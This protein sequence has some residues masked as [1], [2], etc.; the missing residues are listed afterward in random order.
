[1]KSLLADT[2][3]QRVHIPEWWGL[4]GFLKTHK[5]GLALNTLES[6]GLDGLFVHHIRQKVIRYRMRR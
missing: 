6:L 5:Y 1:M 4:I 2:D 3:L